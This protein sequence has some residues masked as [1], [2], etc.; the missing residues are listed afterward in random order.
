MLA[1]IGVIVFAKQAHVAL[2]VAP[3]AQKNIALLLEIP[4]SLM[5]MTPG[6]AI[7]GLLSLAILFLKPL[8][9]NK[10]VQKIPGPM[11]VLVLSIP[12]GM[13]YNLAPDYLVKLPSNMLSGIATPDF[14]VVFT[15]ESV[16]W[17]VIFALIGS[18]ESLLSAKAVDLLDPYSRRTNLNRDLLAIGARTRCQRLSAACQ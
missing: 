3:K 17:I 13:Y 18:L 8:V 2:G 11:I 5:N 10:L 14:S 16:Q 6:I 1:A 9:K 7:I 15:A 12:L 4:H